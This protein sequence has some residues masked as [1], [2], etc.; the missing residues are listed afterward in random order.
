MKP[1]L[2]S[3]RLG[4]CW[5]KSMKSL[6][7]QY[8]LFQLIADCLL[9]HCRTLLPH[10]YTSCPY[11]GPDQ[12]KFLLALSLVAGP[13]LS[14]VSAGC[15]PSSSKETCFF[16]AWTACF[17]KRL[18]RRADPPVS[19]LISKLWW[20][21]SSAVRF[22][23]TVPCAVHLLVFGS[24]RKTLSPISKVSFEVRPLSL[25]ILSCFWWRA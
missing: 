24:C 5:M 23:L 11:P 20:L 15:I 16:R 3:P 9:S 21:P 7:I 6:P 8:S 18:L 4:F 13:L 25:A 10:F 2:L 19:K 14:E 22:K 17:M 12:V 1:P